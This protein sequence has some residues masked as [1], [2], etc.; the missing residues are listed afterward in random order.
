MESP[1]SFLVSVFTD[2]KGKGGKTEFSREVYGNFNDK[3]IAVWFATNYPKFYKPK[4]GES[5]IVVEEVCGRFEE[6]DTLEL[7]FETD[8]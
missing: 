1:N 8:L 2:K 5:R 3:S 4:D 7:V 6:G